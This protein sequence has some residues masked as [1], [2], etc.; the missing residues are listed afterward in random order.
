[1]S[2]AKAFLRE[3]GGSF[4]VVT[5]ET[6]AVEAL[7]GRMGVEADVRSAPHAAVPKLLACAD[8]GL[9]LIKTG[10]SSAASA[11]TKVGEYLATGLAVAASGAGDLEDQFA[12]ARASFVVGADESAEVIAHRLLQA[13]GYE[14]R[15]AESRDLA[16]RHYSLEGALDAYAEIYR[17]WGVFP[18]A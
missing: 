16:E 8:A 17:G 13:T 4:V 11:P 7:A 14:H 18:C 10:F 15:Q 12:S 6:D 3:S 2:V 1:M 9:A 5:K